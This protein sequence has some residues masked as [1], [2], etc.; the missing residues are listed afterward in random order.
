[1]MRNNKC[2][3][4]VLTA[5]LILLYNF[6]PA[7]AKCFIHC[8][9]VPTPHITPPHVDLPHL[10]LGHGVSLTPVGVAPTSTVQK[11]NDMLNKAVTAV[12]PAVNQ[13]IDAGAKSVTAELAPLKVTGK[14]IAGESTL[15]DAGKSL[16]HANGD[17]YV[18]IGKAVSETN[19]A[20]A[21]VKVIAAESIG[22]DVGK[23]TMQLYT[24][25]DRLSVEFA[26]TALIA[27]GG[28]LQGVPPD[29]VLAAPLAAALR[30]AEEQ[31]LPNSKPLPP[32]VMSFFKGKY[33]DDLLND[34]RFAIS[35]ISISVPDIT[36]KTQKAVFGNDNAVTVGRVTVFSQ[37][38][39]DSMHWWAHELQHQVQYKSWGVDEFAFQ[40]MTECHKVESDA[41]AQAQRLVPEGGTPS[42][43]C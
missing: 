34:A 24:G 32:S 42:L 28:V 35:S 9:T 16:A 36:N 21:N 6:V 2:L 15:A 18:A 4:C 43:G 7:E 37:D 19:A 27:G 17:K 8:I 11:A 12:T 5:F 3:S 26:A 31:F 1:M 29:R 40:Y 25:P 41:E 38:P 14:L 22:G 33:P 20:S 39:A 10:D 30:A 13:V 23:A